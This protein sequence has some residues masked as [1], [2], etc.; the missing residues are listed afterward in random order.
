MRQD[1][2]GGA[3]APTSLLAWLRRPAS[4][5]AAAAR[6]RRARWS[7]RRG[8]AQRSPRSRTGGFAVPMINR[9]CLHPGCPGRTSHGAYCD[10]HR[11][12]RE[13]MQR[14]N[15]RERGYRAGWDQAAAAFKRE[16]PMCG[17]RPGGEKPVGSR[18]FDEGKA[19]PAYAVDHIRPHRG[20]AALFWDRANLQSLCRSCHARKTAC[21]Q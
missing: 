15:F 6:D 8:A 21:G 12:S 10:R 2:R 13:R 18:C 3:E 16:F 7:S 9:L 17:Q 11:G 14:G 1:V 4:E 19:T 20:D 5:S